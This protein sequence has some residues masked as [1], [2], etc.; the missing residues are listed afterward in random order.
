M[1]NSRL[2]SRTPDWLY[3]LIGLSMLTV[4]AIDLLTMVGVITWLFY[5]LPLMLCLWVW[6]PTVPI[7]MAVIATLLVVIDYFFSED[8]I[9][10]WVAQ[11]NRGFGLITLW[12]FAFMC[13]QMIFARLTR[14]HQNWLQSGQ[15]RFSTLVIGEQTIG[16]LGTGVLQ[17]LAEYLTAHVGTLYAV[18][19]D[20]HLSRAAGYALSAEDMSHSPVV[21]PGEGLI[22]QAATQNKLMVV[23]DVPAD[24]LKVNSSL[25]ARS[26]ASLV[27]APLTADG[28]VL[29][30]LELGFLNTVYDG[31]LELLKRLSEPLGVALR[32][33]QF[34]TERETLLE[35]TQ[36]QAEELQTQQE[37]LQVANEELEQQSVALRESQVRLES[38]QAELEQSN[39]QLEEHTQALT[40]HNEDL[41][42]ARRELL[43]KAQELER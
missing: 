27:I 22:G 39:L 13:R 18:G 7:V 20:S 1:L 36:R 26:P 11:L 10:L 35:E 38:Q 23:R 41:A 6:R 24:Y 16:Q 34:R 29:G 3:A 17:F 42:V 43:T 25:G 28:Q 9:T 8:G 40:R 2:E 12:A 15:T 14:E 4:F 19:R 37:E 31:D 33:L 32:T 21:R 5:L 30:V